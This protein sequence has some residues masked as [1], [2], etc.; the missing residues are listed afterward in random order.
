[1]K[2]LGKGGGSNDNLKKKHLVEPYLV[3]GG[4]SPRKTPNTS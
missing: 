3:R 2:K 1:M 4:G